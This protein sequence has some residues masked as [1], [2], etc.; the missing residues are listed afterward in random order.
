MESIDLRMRSTEN[1]LEAWRSARIVRRRKC[2]RPIG[3]HDERHVLVR[4]QLLTPVIRCVRPEKCVDVGTA[5]EE[6]I[7]HRPMRHVGAR[8][9]VIR[10]ELSDFGLRQHDVG[11]LGVLRQPVERVDLIVMKVI[12]STVTTEVGESPS[13]QIKVGG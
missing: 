6:P 5:F 4:Q 8:A 11:R 13:K 10:H 3:A 12:R 9:A 7:G 1:E 2:R